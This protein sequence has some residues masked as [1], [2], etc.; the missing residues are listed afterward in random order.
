VA[1]KTR[2]R[3]GSVFSVSRIQES[4]CL[5]RIWLA[6]RSFIDRPSL[7]HSLSSIYTNDVLKIML[8]SHALDPSTRL[9]NFFSSFCHRLHSAFATRTDSIRTL[10]NA[11]MLLTVSYQR[12]IRSHL[13][14]AN[15]PSLQVLHTRK[16][17]SRS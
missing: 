1:G 16:L 12:V 9:P 15:G 7:S 8:P 3:S 5:A 6:A 17:S 4:P 14:S 11:K 2:V 10:I 13:S